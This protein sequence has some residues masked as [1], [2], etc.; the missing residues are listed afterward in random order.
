MG[1]IKNDPKMMFLMTLKVYK[2]TYDEN[3]L[4]IKKIVIIWRKNKPVNLV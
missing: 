1:N 4:Y 3:I 2:S